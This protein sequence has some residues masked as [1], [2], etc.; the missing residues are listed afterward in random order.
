MSLIDNDGKTP[1]RD[2]G[3]RAD[4]R[5]LLNGRGDDLRARVERLAQA[6]AAI[7]LAHTHHNAALVLHGI[8]GLRELGVQISPVG[9]D[10]DRVE[11][12]V[13]TGIVQRLQVVCQPRNGIGLTASR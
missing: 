10:H 6:R 12:R 4:V 5:E 8:N 11:H 9:K 7:L 2:L 13:A 3:L 1:A